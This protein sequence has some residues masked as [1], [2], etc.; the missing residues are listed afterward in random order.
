[1]PFAF[2]KF[3]YRSKGST[4]LSDCLHDDIVSATIETLTSMKYM[5]SNLNHHK[6]IFVHQDSRIATSWGNYQFKVI[7]VR[8][9]LICDTF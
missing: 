5:C 7:D 2:K 6:H 3:N 1:M 9:Q 4:F 8:N